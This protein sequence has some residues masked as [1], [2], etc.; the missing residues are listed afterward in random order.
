[1]H[2]SFVYDQSTM[3]KH[4]CLAKQYNN[5]V[6]RD[7]QSGNARIDTIDVYCSCRSPDDGSPMVQYDRCEEWSHQSCISTKIAKEQ[8]WYCNKC[9]AAI[10]M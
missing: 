6:I 7:R 9:C 1:M 3:R 4:L 10:Y 5:A 8:R 2:A